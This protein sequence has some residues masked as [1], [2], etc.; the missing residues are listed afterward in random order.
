MYS[1]WFYGDSIR[2]ILRHLFYEYHYSPHKLAF[3]NMRAGDQKLMIDL[4]WPYL[5]WAQSS[6]LLW[7][8]WH[9]IMWHLGFNKKKGC[10][11]W[12][13]LWWCL[14]CVSMI[15]CFKLLNII[16]VPQPL[17]LLDCFSYLL[18]VA[19][20]LMLLPVSWD[21]GCWK[22]LHFKTTFLSF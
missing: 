7:R 19:I 6:S 16:Q 20:Q 11:M 3:Q 2:V 12:E 18:K 22:K 1:P 15:Q 13:Q 4:E 14:C 8:G 21:K 17:I 9:Q 10:L 5:V